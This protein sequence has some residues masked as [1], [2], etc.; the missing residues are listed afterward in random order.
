[1][2]L[3]SDI[4]IVVVAALVVQPHFEATLEM[5]RQ[6]LRHLGAAPDEV[7]RLTDAPQRD[8]HLV[9]PDGDSPDA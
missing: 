8:L 7:E 2:G 9:G 6:A 3:A 1:M 5:S 4:V